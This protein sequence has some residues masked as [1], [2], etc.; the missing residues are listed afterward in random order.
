MPA[1]SFNA[2]VFAREDKLP[3]LQGFIQY[4]DN[5]WPKMLYWPLLTGLMLIA[6]VG[7]F[8]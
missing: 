5:F 4:Q 6:T 1:V 7:V 3:L 8:Y 2:M